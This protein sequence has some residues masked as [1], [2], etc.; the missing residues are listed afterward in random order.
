MMNW[1]I[2]TEEQYNRLCAC[3]SRKSDIVPIAKAY[4]ISKDVDSEMGL[5]MAFEHI[6]MNGQF[7][8]TTNE[9]YDDM[10]AELKKFEETRK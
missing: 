3:C 2:L 4:M 10:L 9:E 7:F 1:S 5:E 8:D 6:D